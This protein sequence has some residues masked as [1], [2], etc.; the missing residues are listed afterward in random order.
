M[1]CK[2]ADPGWYVKADELALDYD[3]EVG[4][5]KNG[6]IYFR[7]VPIFHSPWLSLL[8]EQCPQVRLP[9]ANARV[10]QF[11]RPDAVRAVLLEHR[12]EHGRD[13]LAAHLFEAGAQM[14]TE[15]RYLDPNFTSNLRGEYL[16]SDKRGEQRRSLRL[17]GTSPAELRAGLLG[18]LNIA[19]VSD[20]DYFT[21]LSSRSR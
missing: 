11:Q 3:R 14:A 18:H 12:P 19:G 20:D 8:A 10:E 13:D 5:G 15:F 4:E 21:D 1:T 2:P 7:D 9:D 17:F 16:P 6:T